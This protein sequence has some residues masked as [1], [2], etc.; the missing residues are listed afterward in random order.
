M[1]KYIKPTVNENKTIITSVICISQGE[2]Q[3]IVDAEG[4]FRGDNIEDFE[5]DMMFVQSC[6]EQEETE[7][8]GLW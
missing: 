2:D 6:R 8:F 5:D 3:E 1:K 7:H 4:R